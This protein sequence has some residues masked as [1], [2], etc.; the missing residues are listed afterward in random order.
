[1]NSNPD[2]GSFWKGRILMS[3][4]SEQLEKPQKGIKSLSDKENE[5]MSKTDYRGS[6]TWKF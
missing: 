3:I 6:T 1:M 5:E 2:L 4:V